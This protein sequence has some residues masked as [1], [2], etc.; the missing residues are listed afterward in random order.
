MSPAIR[1]V[2]SPMPKVLERISGGYRL[3]M[4][5]FWLAE[6]RYLSERMD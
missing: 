2:A 5:V 3:G 1:P 6:S 4:E